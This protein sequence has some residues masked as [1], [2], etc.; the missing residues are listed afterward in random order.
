MSTS[1]EA[2]VAT[3]CGLKVLA[4]SIITDLVSLEYDH[5]EEAD[6]AAICQVAQMKAKDAEKI[7][8]YF[9]KKISENPSLI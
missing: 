7:V 8:S 6:H 5:E 1:H 9:L 4:F 3:Y 2:V